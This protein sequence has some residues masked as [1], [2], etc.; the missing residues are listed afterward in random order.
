MGR[1][2]SGALCCDRLLGCCPEE[3][4]CAMARGVTVYGTKQ[5]RGGQVANDLKA[6]YEQS[7]GSDQ[8]TAAV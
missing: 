8:A 3:L 7:A 1:W 4:V 2:L 5:D 6:F